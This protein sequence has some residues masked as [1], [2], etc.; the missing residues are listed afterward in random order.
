MSAVEEARRFGFHISD[1]WIESLTNPQVE[2][3]GETVTEGEN[4]ETT[5][6]KAA[7]RPQVNLNNF[8]QLKLSLLNSDFRQHPACVSPILPVDLLSSQK[9]QSLSGPI[10]LQIV[11][12]QNIAVSA[13]KRYEDHHVN[14]FLNLTLTDGH[15][16][17]HAVE[18]ETIT[19]LKPNTPPGGKILWKGGEVIKG[20][21]QLTSNNTQFLGGEVLHLVESFQA[22][23]NALKYRE[24]Q[25]GGTKGVKQLS[26]IQNPPKFELKLT[27]LLAAEK[28]PS[29]APVQSVD[30]K[31]NAK[32]TDQKS[33]PPSVPAVPEK[34]QL[35]QNRR[36]DGKK[37]NNSEQSSKLPSPSN[38]D[39][40]LSEIKEEVK[41]DP[42]KQTNRDNKNKN[43]KEGKQPPQNQEKKHPEPMK[44]EEKAPSPPL[45]L[46]LSENQSHQKNNNP[47]RQG[48]NNRQNNR[49]NPQTIK[50]DPLP[51][52]PAL[53][54][55]INPTVVPAPAVVPPQPPSLPAKN[56]SR[57]PEI[58][59]PETNNARKGRN[60]NNNNRKDEKI[61]VQ[62][63]TSNPQPQNHPILVATEPPAQA[64]KP[65]SSKPSDDH[66]QSK[67]NKSNNRHN[68]QR[69]DPSPAPQLIVPAADILSNS[70]QPINA[71]PDPRNDNRQPKQERGQR[72]GNKGPNKD[73]RALPV[74]PPPAS[75]PS[76]R[77]EEKSAPITSNDNNANNNNKRRE[78]RGQKQQKAENRPNSSHTTT[79]ETHS[80]PNTPQSAPAPATA[81]ESTTSLKPEVLPESHSNNN[82]N[83]QDQRNRRNKKDGNIV[84]EMKSLT[85]SLANVGLTSRDD[86]PVRLNT[87]VAKNM[88]SASLGLGAK[89]AANDNKRSNSN[90][91][92]K[93]GSTGS[94]IVA[95]T[96]APVREVKKPEVVITNVDKDYDYYNDVNDG[97]N[98]GERGGGGGGRGRGGRG[99]RGG[100][101]SYPRGAGRGREAD[102]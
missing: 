48:N 36:Q 96:A 86:A 51:P 38:P 46:G 6:P 5:Q 16:K 92:S 32:K 83:R 82:N 14:R 44:E 33:L 66:R 8:Q 42:P 13:K 37:K 100:R 4:N 29:I 52:P 59:T 39:P 47:P 91:A 61:E 69:R 30:V 70:Q 67:S 19:G 7:R 12:V 79:H 53:T 71:L 31:E 101:R 68:Q 58:H 88:I 87:S 49:R 95:S 22:N 50:S 11:S 74:P 3:K 26:R 81:A 63:N 73:D 93:Q 28:A 23:I 15:T 45:N 40:A 25:E 72:K 99:G 56:E 9:S 20:K 18:M 55:P 76:E 34:S 35:Q 97:A 78:Q 80:V 60:K 90:T 77:V 10:V 21:L 54:A 27:S 64:R 75:L 17:V 24:L 98:P 57:N 85:A 43:K 89:K 65:E 102:H 1:I 62:G 2:S 84:E 94:G 41:N